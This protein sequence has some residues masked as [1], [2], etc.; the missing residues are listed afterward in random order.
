MTK[1][2]VDSMELFQ[3]NIS[4]FEEKEYCKIKPLELLSFVC[5]FV[6]WKY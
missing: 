2:G 5:E 6:F 4:Y 3:R 1:Y